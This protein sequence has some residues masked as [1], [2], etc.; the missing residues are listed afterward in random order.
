MEAGFRRFAYYGV[1]DLWYSE[2][3]GAGFSERV[4]AVG[5][6]CAAFLAPNTLGKHVAWVH[7][8]QP[9]CKWIQS[10]AMPVGLLACTDYRARMALEACKR[11]GVNVPSDMALLGVNN[12]ASA[13]DFCDP[14]LSSVVRNAE[15]V[16]YEAAALLDRLMRGKPPPSGDLL[17]PPEGVIQRRSTDVI[18][19]DDPEVAAAVRYMRD[20]LAESITIDDV[21]REQGVSRRWLEHSFRRAMRRTPHVYVNFLRIRRARQLIAED[22]KITLGAIAKTCGFSDVKRLR[23][24]FARFVGVSLA[25]YRRAHRKKDDRV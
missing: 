21:A 19:I 9:L 5:A 23:A 11:L 16:G 2:E 20:H 10:L 22:P 8:G 15:R 12:D 14:P 6:E 17:V 7:V 24:A 3:R 13:C 4:K 1:Q 25:E 18:A